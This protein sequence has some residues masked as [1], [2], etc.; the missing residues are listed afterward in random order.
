MT[1]W[2]F[3]PHP[4]LFP[5]P[6]QR[7]CA[8]PPPSP[9]S[10]SFS[11]SRPSSSATSATSARRGPFWLSS[12]VSSSYYRVSLRTCGLGD[13]FQFQGP[14]VPFPLSHFF[15]VWPGRS[16]RPSLSTN[17]LRCA[18]EIAVPIAK[19]P[20]EDHMIARANWVLIRYQALF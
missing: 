5:S 10:A 7:Q 18:M 2:R 8:R 4:C 12:L 20:L 16:C 19:R 11:C 6:P 17:F 13:H 15:A 3:P 9:W 1:H 14:V